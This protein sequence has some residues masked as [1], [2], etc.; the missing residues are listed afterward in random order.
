[1]PYKTCPFRLSTGV[2]FKKASLSIKA[3]A[4][5]IMARGSFAYSSAVGTRTS[6]TKDA[7]WKTEKESE[8]RVSKSKELCRTLAQELFRLFTKKLNKDF[9]SSRPCFYSKLRG[10]KILALLTWCSIPPKSS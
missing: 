9:D 7:S 6:F 2:H 4:S 10:S 8:Y 3:E 5:A 1:M